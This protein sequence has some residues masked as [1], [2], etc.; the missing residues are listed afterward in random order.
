[1]NLPVSQSVQTL[2]VLASAKKIALEMNLEQKLPKV[3]GDL[4]KICQVVN[5]LVSNAIKFTPRGGKVKVSTASA[6][7]DSAPGV[8]IAVAD[9]G[10]GISA[11]DQERIFQ[12]F[13]RGRDRGT[14]G[15]TG[16]GL[17]L[18]ICKEIVQLH[19]GTLA[20]QSEISEGSVF[21]VWLPAQT[22][23][24]QRCSGELVRDASQAQLTN[25][26]IAC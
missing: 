1:M 22:A 23:M 15:E 4:G 25:R 18:S 9:T 10:T 6:R 16:T 7:R 17:G 20:V 14:E 26:S 21:V 12:R 5:N 19:G 8:E 11:S 24:G 2:K 3:L 13:R